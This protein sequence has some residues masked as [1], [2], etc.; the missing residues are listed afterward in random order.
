M[1]DERVKNGDITKEEIEEISEI[2]QEAID[3]ETS[4]DIQYGT[5]RGHYFRGV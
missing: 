3:G 2:F 5:T 1:K 4:F